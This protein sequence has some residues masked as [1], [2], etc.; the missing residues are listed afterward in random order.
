[1]TRLKKA[2]GFCRRALLAL[3]ALALM[4]AL[5]LTAAL[6]YKALLAMRRIAGIQD[7]ALPVE[8]LSLPAGTRIVALGEATHGSAE[9]QE[10][11]LTVLQTL[12]QQ[13]GFC[14]FALEVDFGEGLALNDYIQGGPGSA[15]Q[16]L[17]ATSYPIYHTSQMAALLDWM[18]AYN[19]SAPAEKALRFYGFDMQNTAA[20]TRY[21]TE[22]CRLLGLDTQEPTAAALQEI[23]CLAAADSGLDAETALGLLQPLALLEAALA[24]EPEAGA[25]CGEAVSSVQR[26]NAAQAARVLAQTMESWRGYGE[27]YGSYRDACM[28]ENVAWIAD[29]EQALGAGGVLVAAHNGHVARQWPQGA[30]PMGQTLAQRYGS[31][32]YSIGTGFFTATVNIG[33]SS[34]VSERRERGIHFFCSA[35]PLGWQARFFEGGRYFLDFSAVPR[36]SALD[37]QLHSV[38]S[39]GSIGEGYL[40]LWYLFPQSSYRTEL[41]P[42]QSYDGMIYVHH[43]SPTQVIS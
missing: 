14:A 24:A 27:E 2:A 28:A 1:M 42:A 9:F 4:A 7:C 17:A 37:T 26:Q 15:M 20:S 22:I 36:G 18:R 10:L 3:A 39:M 30:V 38:T 8:A 29:R 21:L 11:K 16:A 33:A 32:Y 35:D 13:Y 6:N 25:P 41:V 19:E 31:A 43:A 12:V 40:W 23:Q 5:G 34:M